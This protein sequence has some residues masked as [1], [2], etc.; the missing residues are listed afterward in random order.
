M[1]ISYDRFPSEDWLHR[2][3]KQKPARC[4]CATCKCYVERPSGWSPFCI[5]CSNHCS[6]QWGNVVSS[7]AHEDHEMCEASLQ[8]LMNELAE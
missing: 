1:P 7:S 5:F 3:F 8:I 4:S 6:R 2:L